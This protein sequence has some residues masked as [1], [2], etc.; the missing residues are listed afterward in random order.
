MAPVPGR[1]IECLRNQSAPRG[2]LRSPARQ[3]PPLPLLSTPQGA[4]RPT[5]A[6]RGE[7]WEHPESASQLSSPGPLQ[8]RT[9]H[10]AAR[11]RVGG[12]LSLLLP[13]PPF[14]R[15]WR[16]IFFQ[17]FSL[18]LGPRPPAA[19][20]HLQLG[21][22]LCMRAGTGVWGASRFQSSAAQGRGHQWAKFVLDPFP[23]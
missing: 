1:N 14:C 3:Q 13:A 5:P 10:M 23:G 11:G 7:D 4:G 18:N 17:E 20:L 19:C 16:R 15:P 2:S 22:A 21:R 9:P 8:E 6:Q 12:P